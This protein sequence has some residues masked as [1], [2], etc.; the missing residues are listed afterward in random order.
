[1]KTGVKTRFLIELILA[2]VAYIKDEVAMFE[3]DEDENVPEA[4]APISEV[5]FLAAKRGDFDLLEVLLGPSIEAEKKQHIALSVEIAKVEETRRIYVFLA[6]LTQARIDEIRKFKALDLA[7][8]DYG[9][10]NSILQK[11]VVKAIINSQLDSLALR[12]GL[13]AEECREIND[14]PLIKIQLD[15]DPP[16]G[17][18]LLVDRASGGI[19]PSTIKTFLVDN[20]IAFADDQQ[21][22]HFW[23]TPALVDAFA[24]VWRQRFKYRASRTTI[25]QINNAD[26]L[27]KFL[28]E[29]VH[30]L[31]I[32]DDF[33]DHCIE[34]N[35]PSAMKIEELGN[36][37]IERCHRQRLLIPA[38]LE[39][40]ANYSPA[41]IDFLTHALYCLKVELEEEG[42]AHLN[43]SNDKPKGRWLS[44][45][46]TTY[47]QNT[48]LHLAAEYKRYRIVHLLMKHGLR[49]DTPN[50]DGI[51]PVELSGFEPETLIDL[52]QKYS[53]EKKSDFLKKSLEKV[54]HYEAYAKGILNSGVRKFF[55]RIFWNL[56]I[57][58]SRVNEEIPSLL[59]ELHAASQKLSDMEFAISA[60]K[61]YHNARR[62]LRRH[63]ELHTAIMQLIIRYFSEPNFGVKLEDEIHTLMRITGAGTPEGQRVFE[64]QAV[65]VRENVKRLEAAIVEK[66]NMIACLQGENELLKREYS[67]A[68]E[69]ICEKEA[70]IK[71]QTIVLASQALE[72]Q[73][74]KE[75]VTQ[76]GEIIAKTQTD[77]AEMKAM[78]QAFMRSHAAPSASPAIE[79]PATRVSNHTST[80]YSTSSEAYSPSPVD[81]VRMTQLRYSGVTEGE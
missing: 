17:M 27:E 50:Q 48:L 57:L 60:L 4:V 31:K 68:V 69:N 34:M 25:D 8:Q 1:M 7:Y 33:I 13:F 63:S 67:N 40:N 51:S 39:S 10:L 43:A 15:I 16:L 9:I 29:Q 65:A 49:L 20:H 78:M 79:I 56:S 70:I 11:K 54:L 21:Y 24:E 19:D 2:Q 30:M 71:E 22:I 64:M 3:S 58:E 55:Y 77:L 59:T 41:L 46:I 12:A 80:L 73:S 37:F 45:D 75:T 52:A 38:L 62:G 44:C 14:E 72:M 35:R 53:R 66:G 18:N 23:M 5:A 81:A 26:E 6:A 36:H 28:A 61:L 42:F 47:K 32:Y 76:Q 74:L